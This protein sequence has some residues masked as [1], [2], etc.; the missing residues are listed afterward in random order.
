MNVVYLTWGETPRS[1]GVFGSQVLKN[2]ANIKNIAA[3]SDNYCFISAL[4]LLNSGI[5]REKF[6]YLAEIQ[7]V[8][9]LLNG[10][11]FKIIPIFSPQN[12]IN[13]NAYTFKLFHFMSK[14]FLVN[15][16]EKINPDI[17]HC[18]SYH[19]AYAALNVKNLYKLKYKIVFD[20]RSL[21]PEAIALLKHQ[22]QFDKNYIYLKEVEKKLLLYCDSVVTVS[23]PM[24]NSYL[25]TLQRKYDLVY[26]SADCHNF[27]T[28]QKTEYLENNFINVCYLGAIEE[29][30][31]H[32]LSDLIKLFI[33]LNSIYPK[34]NFKIITNSDHSKVRSALKKNHIVNFKIV[35]TKSVAHLIEELNQ[36]HLGVLS[37]FDPTQNFEK[38]LSKTVLAVKTAEY[39][40]SGIPM[41][42]NENCT[43]AANILNNNNIGITYNPLKL[44]EIKIND[45]INLLNNDTYIRCRNFSASNFDYSVNAN[46]YLDIYTRILHG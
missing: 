8:K 39:L 7:E 41:L 40:S 1:Y 29:N 6:K 14:Y 15:Y 32:K 11:T 20:A 17:V 43:A 21:W 22:N 26:L 36:Q 46:K 34:F 3:G 9:K 25:E 24:T 10:V 42:C 30:S 44:N 31:W 19:A 35:G 2:F 33:H 18:R 13:S 12:F 38:V 4:P 45:I 23:E 5:I 37:Y 28:V 27:A 16:L